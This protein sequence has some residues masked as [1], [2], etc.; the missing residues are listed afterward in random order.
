MYSVFQT[1]WHDCGFAW[2]DMEEWMEQKHVPAMQIIHIEV[3][4]HKFLVMSTQGNIFR[5][6]FVFPKTFYIFTVKT[7]QAHLFR[8]LFNFAVTFSLIFSHVNSS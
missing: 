5:Y 2:S 4:R 6:L 7:M 3:Y 1:V 8:Y